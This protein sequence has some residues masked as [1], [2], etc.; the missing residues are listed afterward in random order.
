MRKNTLRNIAFMAASIALFLKLTLAGA[1]VITFDALAPSYPISQG[2]VDVKIVGQE[3]IANS[4]TGATQGSMGGGLNISWD[5]SILQLTAVQSLF[6]GDNFFGAN[7]SVSTS[8]GISTLEG[9]S[10]S[11]FM[12]GTGAANFDIAKLS[13]TFV[14]PGTSALDLIIGG[15][16][17]RDVWADGSGLIDVKPNGVGGTITVSG[18]PLPPAL[19]LFGSSLLGMVSF[20]R[21]RSAAA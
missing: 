3:F 7:G 21:R 1:A 15:I 4:A 19:L 11:S 17:G 16:E 12:D 10:V 2:T 8:N 20:S 9:L 5:A 6:V 18:V 14:G 13:F